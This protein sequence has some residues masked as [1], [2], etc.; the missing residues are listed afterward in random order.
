MKV[1]IV[2]CILFLVCC[3]SLLTAE[4]TQLGDYQVV[5]E[6]GKGDQAQVFK[7]ETNTKK[8]V[9]LKVFYTPS[10]YKKVHP[11]RAAK[12]GQFFERDGTSKAALAEYRVGEAL[13]HPAICR[14]YK[15][16]QL[17]NQSGE[18][19]TCIVME[20]VPG[21]SLTK[22]QIAT[23]SKRESLEL[24]RSLVSALRYSFAK[25][26]IHNDLWSDNIFINEKGKL[27]LI[28][29]GS[30]DPLPSL[31]KGQKPMGSYKKYYQVIQRSIKQLLKLGNWS[32]REE[33]KLSA[34][35]HAAEQKAQDCPIALE[36]Q[37]AIDANLALVDQLLSK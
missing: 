26:Y 2:R 16:L 34:K 25:G 17:T 28:D 4:I 8:I 35:L 29:L 11:E 22:S 7:A 37:E 6:L 20:Y 27:K 30:Y 10:E 36:Y 12:I 33:E 13:R 24:A 19:L 15:K 14:L 3:C 5:K 9:A 23:M 18:K 1:I 31:Q 21:K 32:F